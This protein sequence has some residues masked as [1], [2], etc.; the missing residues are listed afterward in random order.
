[1]KYAYQESPH[2]E[3]TDSPRGQMV[4]RKRGHVFTRVSISNKSPQIINEKEKIKH[5]SSH[6]SIQTLIQPEKLYFFT[7][8]GLTVS[9]HVQF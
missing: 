9:I 2:S 1:M 7:F 3:N 8:I 6:V 4:E 5:S